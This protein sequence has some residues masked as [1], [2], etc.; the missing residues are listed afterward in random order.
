VVTTVAQLKH[1]QHYLLP[2]RRL[3]E[4][5]R[6]ELVLQREGGRQ[7]PGPLPVRVA[8][9]SFRDNVFYFKKSIP[10]VY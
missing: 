8:S 7:H 3:R 9:V 4:S 10:R 2:G 5:R 6:N 1:Q